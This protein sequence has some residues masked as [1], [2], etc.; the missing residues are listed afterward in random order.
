M[1]GIIGGRLLHQNRHD[2]A[3]AALKTHRRSH[4]MNVPDDLTG[5]VAFIVSCRFWA[6]SVSPSL[7]IVFEQHSAQP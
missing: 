5:Q 2:T 4:D 3:Q 7:S 6:T 1:K